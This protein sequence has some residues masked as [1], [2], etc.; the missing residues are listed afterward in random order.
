[1][2]IYSNKMD[3]IPYLNSTGFKH[4]MKRVSSQGVCSIALIKLWIK[5]VLYYTERWRITTFLLLQSFVVLNYLF[6]TS[7][8][9]NT[10]YLFL[11]RFHFGQCTG[12]STSIFFIISP[13]T[14]VVIKTSSSRTISLSC[15]T[16]LFTGRHVYSANNSSIAATFL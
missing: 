8:Y 2:P 10:L 3:L 1:M 9:L 11:V 4:I 16:G 7:I 5:M 6:K 12:L 15:F 14:I 13:F